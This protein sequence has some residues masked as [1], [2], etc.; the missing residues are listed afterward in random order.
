MISAGRAPLTCVTIPIGSTAFSPGISPTM[1]NVSPAVPPGILSVS[2]GESTYSEG[3]DTQAPGTA[4]YN[5]GTIYVEVNRSVIP[6]TVKKPQPAGN[7]IES[8]KPALQTGSLENWVPIIDYFVDDGSFESP[9]TLGE[10]DQPETNTISAMAG[11]R[12]P[13]GRKTV[14]SSTKT[15]AE[16][17]T[18]EAR[19][20]R[21][22]SSIQLGRKIGSGGYGSVYKARDANGGQLVIKFVPKKNLAQM[23][24][25]LRST[26]RLMRFLSGQCDFPCSLCS[27]IDFFEDKGSFYV[28]MEY[29]DGAQT[30]IPDK[31]AHDLY[32]LSAGLDE[33]NLKPGGYQREWIRISMLELV[34]AAIYMMTKPGQL[35][36]PPYWI[37]DIKPDNILVRNDGTIAF[38][39]HDLLLSEKLAIELSS[40][41]FIPGTA[42]Y[43]A[44][45][46][47]QGRAHANEKTVVYGLG[48]V[49]WQLI[50]VLDIGRFDDEPY[51]EGLFMKHGAG[52]AFKPHAP[53]RYRKL[54]AIA[55]KCTTP[56]PGNRPSLKEVETMLESLSFE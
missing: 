48:V 51:L 17:E 3:V 47:L 34:R 23:E 35:G 43:F 41:Q 26:Y 24:E 14:M 42:E 18:E 15:A 12:R 56:D 21:F 4:A 54:T 8:H 32:D 46:V 1:G 25:S 13:R 36:Y 28:V 49:L 5:G 37:T 55:E 30:P 19:L 39:D 10:T 16:D 7:R 20:R 53:R 38:G 9:A 45:E 52:P 40:R 27:I 50:T 2:E 44:P 31:R 29:F 22:L 11:R 33:A 6:Q